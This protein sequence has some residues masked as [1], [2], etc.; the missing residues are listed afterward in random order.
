LFSAVHS[1]T[2]SELPLR[3][4]P[5]MDREFPA[6]A[7]R[8]SPTAPYPRRR[9]RTSPFFLRFRILTLA[10]LN[11]RTW[12]FFCLQKFPRN[13]RRKSRTFSAVTHSHMCDGAGNLRPVKK[14]SSARDGFGIRQDVAVVCVCVCVCVCVQWVSVGVSGCQWVPVD[15]GSKTVSASFQSVSQANTVNTNAR[16]LK[17][18]RL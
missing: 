8:P 13:F 17:C 18:I 2:V 1:R 9:F 10:K 4:P 5:L 11:K 7:P 12:F 14:Y 16:H 6:P 15:R 3:E